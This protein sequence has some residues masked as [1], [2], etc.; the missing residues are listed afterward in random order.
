MRLAILIFVAI[1]PFCIVAAMKASGGRS[2]Q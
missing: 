2:N 1:A